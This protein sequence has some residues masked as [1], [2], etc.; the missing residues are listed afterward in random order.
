MLFFACSTI[1]YFGGISCNDHLS[2]FNMPRL[3]RCCRSDS[4]AAIGEY[5][6]ALH[7]L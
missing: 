1:S 7:L 5:R 6:V 2:A 3:N 4:L